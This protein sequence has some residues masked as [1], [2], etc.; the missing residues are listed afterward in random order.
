MMKP[1]TSLESEEGYIG[2]ILL[3]PEKIA[4]TT[5]IED[6]FYDTNNKLLFKSIK[7][8]YISNTTIDLITLKNYLNEK[9]ILDQVGGERNLLSLCDRIVVPS[10]SQHYAKIIKEKSKLRKEIKV[11]E[12]GIVKAY[13]GDSCAE[14]VISNLNL[15]EITNDKTTLYETGEKFIQNCIDGNV[16]NIEWLHNEWTQKLGK[17]SNDLIFI[18][19][20][21]STGK[22]AYCLQWFIELARKNK[23][24]LFYSIE[25]NKPEILPRL[26]SY[27]GQ[28]DT[29]KVRTRG[30][31]NHQEVEKMKKANKEVKDL[32]L[33]IKDG[34]ASVDDIRAAAISEARKGLD[35]L[36]IDNLLCINDGGKSFQTKTI[37]Y[38][39][40]TR[41]LLDLRSELNIPIVVLCHP[42][43]NLEI[44]WS[45]DTENL[46]DII[47]LLH[48]I[49]ENGIDVKGKTIYPDSSFSQ[50]IIAM[51]KKNRQ[52][53]CPY[54]RLHFDKSYQTFN[55]GSWE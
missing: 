23:R 42:N 46:A 25:M 52:G 51:F 3:A 19:S 6:D 17:L 45:K 15:N 9:G 20:P 5:L 22:T 53:L 16:G 54:G 12:N 40:I 14:E 50:D 47:L 30:Y 1:P 18:N 27:I 7:D 48:N 37:M 32:D 36:F 2:S 4:T 35:I 28:V 31:T 38:D 39:Y 11:L 24:G 43:A 13:N 21:R 44:S 26:I 10:H 8:M 29:Y 49:D 34:A 33:C 41:R 55:Y